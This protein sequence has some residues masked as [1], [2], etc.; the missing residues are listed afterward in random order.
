MSVLKT[1]RGGRLGVT[2][3]RKVSRRAVDRNRIKRQIRESFRTHQAGLD[4]CDIVVT[5]QAGAAQVATD[6]LRKSLEKHWDRLGRRCAPS[7][8]P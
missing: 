8:S 2:V 1:E 6:M 5:A 4:G 7:S 3:S